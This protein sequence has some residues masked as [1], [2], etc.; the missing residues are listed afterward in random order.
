MFNIRIICMQCKFNYIGKCTLSSPS[1]M[2]YRLFGN[3]YIGYIWI[4]V[5]SPY[6]AVL[7][8]TLLDMLNVNWHIFCMV[9]YNSCGLPKLYNMINRNT[10]RFRLLPK[11]NLY[12]Q[13]YTCEHLLPHMALMNQ[14]LSLI[15]YNWTSFRLWYFK[16]NMY[17]ISIESYF[18][19]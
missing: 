16:R 7:Y 4:S 3:V 12:I 11:L 9:L 6:I 17:F 15:I 18:C 2:R 5:Y 13:L 14:A 1:P 10:F 8:V 19:E